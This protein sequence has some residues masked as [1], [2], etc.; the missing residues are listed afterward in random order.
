MVVYRLLETGFLFRG[1][2]LRVWH[3][4][5]EQFRLES[6]ASQLESAIYQLEPR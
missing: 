5:L 4:R 2:D 1:A 3:R 6:A